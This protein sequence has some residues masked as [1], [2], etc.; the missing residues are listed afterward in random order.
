LKQN[1]YHSVP[2]LLGKNKTLAEYFANQWRHLVG[3]CDLLYTRTIEGRK[4]ILKSRVKSLSSQSN[5]KTEQVN[6][7]VK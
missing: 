3:N 6:K 4:L 2:D 7:W 5:A 1:D